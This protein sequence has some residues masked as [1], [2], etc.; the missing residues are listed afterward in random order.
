MA[1]VA[2]PRA[3]GGPSILKGSPDDRRFP[4]RF[5]EGIVNRSFG[6]LHD[7]FGAVPKIPEPRSQKTF[8]DHIFYKKRKNRGDMVG[9]WKAPAPL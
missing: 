4:E 5:Y 7:P 1:K 6:S 8:Y 9:G 2:Q 3:A